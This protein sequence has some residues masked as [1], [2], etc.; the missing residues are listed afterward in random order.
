MSKFNVKKLSLGEI[1]DFITLLDNSVNGRD[2][3]VHKRVDTKIPY[4][5]MMKSATGEFK[6]DVQLSSA[7]CF[8]VDLSKGGAGILTPSLFKEGHTLHVKGN[9]KDKVFVASLLI[10]NMRKRE[11]GYHYGCKIELLKMLK[12]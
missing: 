1:D 5:Y 7:G 3:R 12:T 4:E 2:N 8:F 11:G 9:G 6:P 10:Q